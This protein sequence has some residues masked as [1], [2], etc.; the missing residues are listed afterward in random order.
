MCVECVNTY[1]SAALSSLEDT[2]VNH[3]AEIPHPHRAYIPVGEKDRK[4]NGRKRN[5][6]WK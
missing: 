3:I 6:Q 1:V 2:W 5:R 4:H